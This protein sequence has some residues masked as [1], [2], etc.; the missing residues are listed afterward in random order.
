MRCNHNNTSAQNNYYALVNLRRPSDRESFRLDHNFN[1][2][3]RLCWRESLPDVD[4]CNELHAAAVVA[5]LHLAKEEAEVPGLKKAF[6]D[7]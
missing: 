2:R 6:E 5:G 7:D 3:H 1:E 4:D